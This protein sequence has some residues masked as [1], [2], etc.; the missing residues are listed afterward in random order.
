MLVRAS[1]SVSGLPDDVV[2]IR[3]P[4]DATGGMACFWIWEPAAV[5]AADLAPGGP[6]Q[7]PQSGSLHGMPS[8]ERIRKNMSA[9][10]S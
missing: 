10:E 3:C 2:H 7:L 6:G 1:G 8:P 4:S 5:L 9:S